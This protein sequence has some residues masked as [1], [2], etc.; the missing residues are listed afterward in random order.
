MVY[1]L[2]LGSGQFVRTNC[3]DNS[4]K[5]IVQLSGQ[6]LW[7]SGQFFWDSNSQISVFRPDFTHCQAVF[8]ISDWMVSRELLNYIDAN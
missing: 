3:P 1:L 5:F 2:G 6:K 4:L 8:V 7:I